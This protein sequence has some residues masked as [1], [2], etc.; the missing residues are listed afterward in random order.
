PSPTTW[1]AV[2]EDLGGRIDAILKGGP[3]RVGLESTVVD[4]TGDEPV[5][6]RHGSIS[7]DDLRLVAPGA[8]ENAGDGA[9]EQRSPGTR[10]RHYRPD[11]RVIVGP[12]RTDNARERHAWLGLRPP[13]APDT[14]AIVRIVPDVDEYARSLFAFFR[15]CEAA[16]IDVIC[17]E[18]VAERGLGRALM[19]RLNRASM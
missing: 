5:V 17:C 2:Q 10:H 6:L 19:D 9:L 15:E 16:G 12:A 13:P 7:L 18:P 14:Y 1:Q 3:T 4:C 8:A 11:A